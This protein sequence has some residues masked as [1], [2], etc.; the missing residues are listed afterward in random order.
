MPAAE[1]AAEAV[2]PAAEHMTEGSGEPAE[3]EAETEPAAAAGPGEN[4]NEGPAVAAAECEGQSSFEDFPEILPAPEL[5]CSEKARER[6]RLAVHNF[7]VEIREIAE[8]DNLEAYELEGIIKN[9]WEDEWTACR[10][11]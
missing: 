9:F 7:A 6:L 4:E 2:N 11:M 3:A 8:E 1:E 10:K 5:R